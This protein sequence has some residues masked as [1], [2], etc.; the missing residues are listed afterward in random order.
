MSQNV[1]KMKRI[2]KPFYFVTIK[3]PKVL[4]AD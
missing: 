3:C 4:N 1:E 2:Y